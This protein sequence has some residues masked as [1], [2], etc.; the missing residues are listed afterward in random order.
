MLE[1]A[2]FMFLAVAGLAE[3]VLA[4]SVEHRCGAAKAQRKKARGTY[5]F[6]LL[7]PVWPLR[8]WPGATIK[9]S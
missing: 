7:I 6:Q 8:S 2:H 1:A 9:S 4:T 5:F 3:N